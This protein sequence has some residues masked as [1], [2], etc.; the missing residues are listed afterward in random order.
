MERPPNQY[1]GLRQ[2]IALSVHF[3]DYVVDLGKRGTFGNSSSSATS[4]VALQGPL[5][6][7]TESGSSDEACLQL[8][9]PLDST[10]ETNTHSSVSVIVDSATLDALEVKG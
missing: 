3:N 2:N 10:Y 9:L 1:Y 8:S 4:S 7:S 6:I 5:P